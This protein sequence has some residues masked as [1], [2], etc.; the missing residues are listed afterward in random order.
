MKSYKFL[1]PPT[2]YYGIGALESCC[3]KLSNL[4]N[5]PLLVTD[6]IMT[7]IGYVDKLVNYLNKQK[8]A[9]SLFNEV[10]TEPT[11]QYIE[12]GL[13]LFKEHHCDFLIALG[14]GSPIDAAK[15]ISLMVS[16]PGKIQDYMGLGKVQQEGPPVVAIPTTSGTGSEA[17]QFTII[18]DT[19]NDIKMLIGSEYIIPKIAIND[20]ILTMSVPPGITAA[21][22]IDALTHAIEAYTSRRHQPLAD[23]FAL[24]S[25]KRI[26]KYLRRAWANGDDEKARSEMMLAAMEAG[27]AFNN[28]SVTIVHGMS[29]PLG[30]LFHIPHGI[31][32]AVLLPACL[33][34]AIMGLPERFVGVAKAIGVHDNN[35]PDL[36]FAKEGVTQIK[37]LCEDVEIPSISVLGIDKNAFM[38]RLDKMA[39]DA[40][41]S[42]SPYN[43]ARKPSKEDIIKIYEKSF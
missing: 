35:L 33:E 40:L 31:S 20:P 32:N 28:S 23:I 30:A 6:K 38:K 36:D 37:K 43:T 19:K 39:S 10:N 25:I 18:T 3:D 22:G 14:G 1:T 26:S 42:G 24:S 9:V 11:D 34:Y 17:T 41:D 4:G 2:I 21:T 7:D 12:N 16:N 13:H 15:A 27:M 8:V 29:R 5:R